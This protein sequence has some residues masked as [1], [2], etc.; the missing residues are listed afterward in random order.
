MSVSGPFTRWPTRSGFDKF[1]GFIGGETNQWAPFLHDGVAPV[2]P[3]H[4][5]DYHVT[6]DLAN[7]AIAWMRFQQALTPDKPFYVYFATG[8]THAPHHVPQEWI[9]KYE[10]KFDMGWDALS[11]ADPGPADRARRRPR[12]NPARLQTRGHRRLGL[13]LGG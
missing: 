9:D 7:Q 11:R 6:T 10:G 4:D 2:E 3:P 1:Y 5:P 12:G 13:A 8:A